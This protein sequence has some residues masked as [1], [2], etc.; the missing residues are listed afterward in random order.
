MTDDAALFEKWSKLCNR[1]YLIAAV[2]SKKPRKIIAKEIG[3]ALKTLNKALR[4][5]GIKYPYI[6]RKQ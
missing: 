3:C 4:Y 2:E 1:D 5:H 6:I